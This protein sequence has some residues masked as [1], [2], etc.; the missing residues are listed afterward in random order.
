MHSWRSAIL[1]FLGHQDLYEQ[2]DFSKP[3]DDPAN[4][5]VRMSAVATYR[6]P[7]IDTD[8]L[9]TTYVAIVDPSGVFTGP[10]QTSFKMITDGL[11]NTVMLTETETAH[12][13]H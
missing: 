5:A 6:C 11:A 9:M 7:S 10:S 13:V 12:A 3:W 4:D 2:I 8:P 1:P